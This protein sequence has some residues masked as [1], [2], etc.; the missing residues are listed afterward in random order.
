MSIGGN[1][2]GGR[3]PSHNSDLKQRRSGSAN[4]AQQEDATDEV[5]TYP[6]L[7]CPLG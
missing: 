6:A 2:A 4:A 1:G 3:A 7:L 5:S